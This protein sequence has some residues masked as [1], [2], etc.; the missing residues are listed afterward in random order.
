MCTQY[1]QEESS[2]IKNSRCFPGYGESA[3]GEKRLRREKLTRQ[4]CRAN[5]FCNPSSAPSIIRFLSPHV[6]S[7]VGENKTDYDKS[8]AHLSK[9]DYGP[10]GAANEPHEESNL[11]GTRNFF[12]VPRL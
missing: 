8:R 12:L 7:S 1:K 2:K 6:R 5:F 10:F 4:V 11:M 3:V 9:G